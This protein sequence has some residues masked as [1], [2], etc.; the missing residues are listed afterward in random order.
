MP[1]NADPTFQLEIDEWILDYLIYIA[2]KDILE[3]YQSLRSKL[4]YN[5]DEEKSD[6]PLQ[7]V[8]CER[9]SLQSKLCGLS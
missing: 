3:C 6:L 4:D 1:T 7:L 5:Y 2:I 9:P 8:V